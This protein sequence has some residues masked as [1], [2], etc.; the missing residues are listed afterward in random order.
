[1]GHLTY[2]K[3]QKNSGYQGHLSLLKNIKR[4]DF[5]MSPLMRYT[6]ALVRQ[7]YLLNLRPM[8]LIHPIVQVK[9]VVTF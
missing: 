8:R 3:R 9:P 2:L 7:A 5:Y 4:H 1:M 6:E